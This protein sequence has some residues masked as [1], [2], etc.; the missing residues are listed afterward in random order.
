MIIDEAEW[1]GIVLYYPETVSKHLRQRAGALPHLMARTALEVFTIPGWW[2]TSHT[3][4]MGMEAVIH[5]KPNLPRGNQDSL[6]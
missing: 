1:F 3:V 6:A 2:E 5:T 4:A